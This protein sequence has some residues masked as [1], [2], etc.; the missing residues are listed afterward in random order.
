[1]MDL[2]ENSYNFYISV[3]PDILLLAIICLCVPLAGIHTLI[4]QSPERHL[5]KMILSHSPVSILSPY[6]VTFGRPVRIKTRILSYSLYLL[7][8]QS[9]G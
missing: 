4:R 5:C 9:K 1:M 8:Y 2:G 7:V 6:P 3:V